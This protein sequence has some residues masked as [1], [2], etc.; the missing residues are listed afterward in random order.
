L[1]ITLYN[2]VFRVYLVLSGLP[3]RFQVFAFSS[4]PIC[5]KYTYLSLAWQV[6]GTNARKVISELYTFFV[7]LCTVFGRKSKHV[8][9]WHRIHFH[10][11]NLLNILVIWN[12]SVNFQSYQNSIL[13][14]SSDTKRTLIHDSSIL[15]YKL[16]AQ[17]ELVQYVRRVYASAINFSCISTLDKSIFAHIYVRYRCSYICKIYSS[18]ICKI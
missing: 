10:K 14:I 12:Y 9:A 2:F 4:D 16:T 17:R 13:L 11:N 3:L 15:V 18:Y 1:K 5:R 8:R 6:Q 7:L